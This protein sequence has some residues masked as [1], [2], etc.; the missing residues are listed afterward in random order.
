MTG[1]ATS[2][3]LLL[4][5][6]RCEWSEE[7]PWFHVVVVVVVVFVDRS[8]RVGVSGALGVEW[9]GCRRPL[10]GFEVECR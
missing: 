2:R 5:G 10:V 3:M 8:A 9:L 7:D 4:H 6:R 1:L